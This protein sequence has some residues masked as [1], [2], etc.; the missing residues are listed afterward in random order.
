MDVDKKMNFGGIG[1]CQY[2]VSI[3]ERSKVG[4]RVEALNPITS[5]KGYQVSSVPSSQ[6]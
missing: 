4:Q 3:N 5:Q 1:R 2:S 6:A